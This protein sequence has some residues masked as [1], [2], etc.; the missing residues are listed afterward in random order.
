M[1]FYNDD[2]K[3]LDKVQNRLRDAKHRGFRSAT[4]FGFKTDGYASTNLCTDGKYIVTVSFDGW[5]WYG[6]FSQMDSALKWGH[7]FLYKKLIEHG[8]VCRDNI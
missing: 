6:V 3:H 5:T 4:D 2:S 1:R 7:D 8:Y